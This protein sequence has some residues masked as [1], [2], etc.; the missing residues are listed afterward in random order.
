[1]RGR[2][3]RW[4]QLGPQDELERGPFIPEQ[5]TCGN[6]FGMSVSSR[7]C[8]KSRKSNHTKNLAKADS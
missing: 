3:L 5:R 2:C 6:R 7:Y 8:C 1:M 4:V